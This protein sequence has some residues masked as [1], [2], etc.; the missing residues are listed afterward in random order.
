MAAEDRSSMAVGLTCRD[1]AAS[2]AFYRDQLGFT[3]KESWPDENAPM[4]CNMLLGG[5][6][7]MLGGAMDPEQ[8]G[9][10]CA[11]DPGALPIAQKLAEAFRDHPAGVGVSVYLEVDDVDAFDRTVRDRGVTP[12]REPVTQFYGI[13]EILVD[14][15]DGYRLVFY[16]A[17]AMES[18]Q[19]CGMPLAGAQPG[20]MYCEHC[21]DDAGRLKPY[22][23]VFEGTVIG[24]FMGM[25]NM[26]RPQ[27]EEAA[28]EHL[29]RMPA[30]AGR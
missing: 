13:R 17:V 3:M 7:V 21:T 1:M 20:Q 23:Q 24:Y 8:L 27:A 26:E 10:M 22:E 12:L 15:P 19:S 28:R 2:V 16:T 11:H 9:E 5:Q 6:S 25:Q 4:W 29:A 14:D 18:C 30:W